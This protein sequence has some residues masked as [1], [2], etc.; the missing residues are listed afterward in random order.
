MVMM[1]MI[2]YG[3]NGDK[4]NDVDDEDERM[5]HFMDLSPEV[6]LLA[7]FLVGKIFARNHKKLI[8]KPIETHF[9][10]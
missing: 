3:N 4:G 2:Q 7:V 6:S 5:M 8:S 1:M 9:S 10:Q